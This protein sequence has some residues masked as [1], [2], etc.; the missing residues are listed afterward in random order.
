MR[1]ALVS[2]EVYPLG[3]GGIGQYVSAAARLLSS[4]A[5]VTILTTSVFRP[6]YE[7]LVAAADSRLPPSG[8]RVAFVQEP[9][10]PEAI[11]WRHVMHC[12]SARTYELLQELYPDGG[13]DL[14]EFPDF[15]GEAFVTLQAAD[16]ADRFL[17]DTRICVRLHTT[18]EMCEILDGRRKRDISSQVLHAMERY[19]LARADR[20]IWQ[21][22]DVLETYRRFYGADALAPATRIRYPYHGEALAVGADSQYTAGESLRILYAGRLERRKGVQNL[23]RAV[24]GSDRA[25]FRLTLVGGD[26]DTAPLGLSMREY[27]EL[28]IADDERIALLGARDRGTV[29][30]LI[31]A[32][33]VIVI[34]S[35]WE[36]WPYAALE[37]LRLN[38]PLLATP[39]GG[40]V[41]M[42]RPGISG[43]LAHGTSA[44]ALEQALHAL[45]LNRSVVTDLVR[46]ESPA[47]L[48]ASLTEPHEIMDGYGRLLA[49]TRSRL[50]TRAASDPEPLVS[51]I[52][53][54]YRASEYV[55]AA[56]E[57]LLTQTYPRI[58]VL[59]VNDGSWEPEDWIVAELAA[60]F[61]VIVVSQMN[62]GL[63][64]A[65]NFGIRQSRGRYVFPL[66]SDNL[67]QPEF[68]ARAVEIL[69]G[70]PDVAYVTAWSRYI[71]PDGTQRTGPDLG[72]EPLGNQAACNEQ[73]NFAGDAAAV[74]R[75]RLFDAGFWYSEELTSFEDWHLYRELARA[76]HFGVVIPERLLSYRVRPDSM[77]A[78][79]A[80][81]RRARLVDEIEAL[82]HEKG[83][84]WTS[85][86]A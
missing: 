58:E 34:P 10:V 39:V 1:V 27:L 11:A 2:R 47:R 30:E 61:P 49:D 17:Q 52:V 56:V 77:Q 3:G 37:P 55:A 53:P 85:S 50:P 33:D 81:P 12:Y 59:L 48:G 20:L 32:H 54:Y 82:L 62:G 24:T 7:E 25:D 70:R 28:A 72:Y 16:T 76:G 69:Q 43:W 57:S 21:G 23:V 13:P 42:V 75:R 64:A 36:C 79:I 8:V 14:I 80:Q 84:Q 9:S 6:A 31:R 41:E 71:E 44:E 60:R 83:V 35:L 63:G 4:V 73:E 29:S 67:A 86:S 38:R 66:D 78:E 45:L 18:A 68:V 22:G 40:L 46:S 5:E 65:R 51:A 26:T 74:M 15:L 19:C